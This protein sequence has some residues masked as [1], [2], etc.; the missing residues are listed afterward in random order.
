MWGQGGPIDHASPCHWIPVR[1]RNCFKHCEHDYEQ[2][3]DRPCRPGHYKQCDNSRRT[4]EIHGAGA[5]STDLG[6]RTALQEQVFSDETSSLSSRGGQTLAGRVPHAQRTGIWGGSGG[7]AIPAHPSFSQL[8]RPVATGAQE[9]LWPWLRLWARPE[10]DPAV[11]SRP[12]R[13]W[14]GGGWWPL[15]KGGVAASA[16]SLGGRRTSQPS[17]PCPY[18]WPGPGSQQP[19]SQ[20]SS[21]D[22]TKETLNMLVILF[23]CVGDYLTQAI[24]F[25]Y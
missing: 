4:G 8:S 18:P 20:R 24:W 17:S 11:T 23:L 2:Q 19:L 1:A 14:P 10:F 25:L 16:H 13:G 15:G 6:F 12:E 5:P 22:Q 3:R 7:P 9:P 21:A